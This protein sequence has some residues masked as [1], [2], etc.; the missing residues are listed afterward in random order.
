[1]TTL[2]WT[3]L[4]PVRQRPAARCNPVRGIMFLNG[5]DAYQPEHAAF[6]PT[7]GMIASC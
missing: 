1:M 2:S 4:G 5:H 7:Y 6:A 3:L